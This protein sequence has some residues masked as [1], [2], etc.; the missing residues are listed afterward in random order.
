MLENIKDDV[1]DF[2]GLIVKGLV[3]QEQAVRE[4]AAIVVGQFAEN[5]V[6]DF[7]ELSSTV[8][9]NLYQMLQAYVQ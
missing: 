6:P 4:G 1:E 5:V 7:L 2:A 9:P 3:D 8:L